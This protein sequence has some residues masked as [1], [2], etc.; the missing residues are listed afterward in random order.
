MDSR[1][2]V[3]RRIAADGFFEAGVNRNI[4]NKIYDGTAGESGI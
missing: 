1:G 4:F 2:N 3:K